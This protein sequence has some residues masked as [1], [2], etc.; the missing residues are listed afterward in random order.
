M[1]LH[2]YCIVPTHRAQYASTL[3]RLEYFLSFKGIPPECPF[4][5][6]VVEKQL[7]IIA[8]DSQQEK[9]AKLMSVLNCLL[10]CVL[11]TCG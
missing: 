2:I 3:R 9:S 4:P 10:L 11:R 1:T 6:Q 7:P 8:R 5:V